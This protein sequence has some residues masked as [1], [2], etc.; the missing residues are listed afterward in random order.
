MK[1]GFVRT[2]YGNLTDKIKSEIQNSIE[3]DIEKFDFKFICYTY[4]EENHRFLIDHGIYSFMKSKESL[5]FPY[6][7]SLRHKL[8]S[9]KY[10]AEDFD[11]FAH[12]DWDCNL[13]AK[14]PDNIFDEMKKKGEMQA[15]LYKWR[16]LVGKWRVAAKDIEEI[17]C[18]ANT[19]F[20][21]IRNKSLPQ[22]AINIY[23]N[24]KLSLNQ[25]KK[26]ND[27]MA[28]SYLFDQLS[29]GWQGL[30]YWKKNFE[31]EYSMQG[32]TPVFTN[33]PNAVFFHNQNKW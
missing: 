17:K 31:I 8:E 14:V 21:Y 26:K 23:D 10:A 4:G 2:L 16:R 13:T 7:Y 29:G 27:E 32:L 33:K 19:S 25:W 28:I 24:D 3:N 20:L 1:T 22:E 18:F 15:C 5:I 30:E 12:V 9:Y 11:E 6:E